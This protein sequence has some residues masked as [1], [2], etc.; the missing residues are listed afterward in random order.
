MLACSGLFDGDKRGYSIHT[1]SAW[2]QHTSNTPASAL[3]ATSAP[4]YNIRRAPL[5]ACTRFCT[6]S[7]LNH[8]NSAAGYLIATNLGIT[9]IRRVP[10]YIYNIRRCVA[11]IH[12]HY[13][14]L[15]TLTLISKAFQ[16]QAKAG[17]NTGGAEGVEDAVGLEGCF[18]K[19]SI[20]V[21][22]RLEVVIYRD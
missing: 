15:S 10:G 16:S 11:F 6:G 12:H 4:G 8:S 19:Q 14:L 5:P 22:L 1:S 17:H 21:F 7:V 18:D 3:M 13:H 2:I 20:F 9:Y